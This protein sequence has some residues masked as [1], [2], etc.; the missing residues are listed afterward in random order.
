M[1]EM[2]FTVVKQRANPY[3]QLGIALVIGWVGILI[4]RLAHIQGAPEYFAAFIAIIFYTLI[5]TVVSIAHPSFF[6]YTLPSYY[7][8]IFLVIVLL[9]SA[10]YTSGVSIWNLEEYRMML[11]SITIFYG[12]AS[13]LVRVLRFMYVAALN[14]K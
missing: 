11:L 9:L 12:V 1:E 5:N 3:V 7:I 4:C 2:D 6:R 8:F 10:R 13:I 14:D